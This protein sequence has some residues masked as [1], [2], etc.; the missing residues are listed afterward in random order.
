MTSELSLGTTAIFAPD[1]TQKLHILA[2]GAKY[3]VTCSSSG[4]HRRNM[5]GGLGNAAPEGICHSW[6]ED[7]RCVSL[8]KILLSND[9]VYNC[10]YCVNRHELDK[11]RASFTPEEVCTIVMNFYRRNYIEGLF[12]SSAVLKNPDYTMEL[13]YQTALLL[14]KKYRFN[15]YI[16]L[17]GI[18]GSDQ[19][20][21]DAAAAVVDRMSFNIELP[22]EHS[23]R[24]LAPQKR[25]EAILLPMS[26]LAGEIAD[27]AP[28]LPAGQTT[29]MIVGASDETDGTILTL[30][31]AL[32][33]KFALKRVY[34][35]AFLLTEENAS[36]LLPVRS[37]P[38]EREH[39]LYQA[40]WLLRFYGFRSDEL[41]APGENFPL[42]LDPKSFWAIK[43]PECFP[44]EVNT[45]PVEVLARVPGIGLRSAYRIVNA[46]RYRRLDFSDLARMK[47]PMKRARHFL[48][49]KG[50][51]MGAT[52]LLAADFLTEYRQTDMFEER[53]TGE[54]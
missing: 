53:L 28:V 34:Y 18:P 47:V 31:D 21:V 27:R 30:T 24:R 3:D 2:D 14:R 25:K 36:S 39:R 8:L 17:K 10:A 54:F 22:S 26:T 20:L 42:G 51:F 52:N 19:R 16:H 45:A 48:T 12:L 32:Y 43:H 5:P 13:L 46:R 15:G 4:S 40:D 7:G 29:Q 37:Q 38:R 35:S 50:K 49:A 6:T 44:V 33:R 11:P 9:C 41:L 23:L 1:L